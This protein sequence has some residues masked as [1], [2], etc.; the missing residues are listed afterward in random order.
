MHTHNVRADSQRALM[1]AAMFGTHTHTS[2]QYVILQ[3]HKLEM[4][5]YYL[6]TYNI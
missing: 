6:I 3:N 2:G 5:L 4:H 1:F